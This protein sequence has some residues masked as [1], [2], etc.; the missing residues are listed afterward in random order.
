MKHKVG[1]WPGAYD[2]T[3]PNE[4]AKYMRRLNKEPQLGFAPATKDLV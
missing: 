4:V 3:E 2:Y 1:G